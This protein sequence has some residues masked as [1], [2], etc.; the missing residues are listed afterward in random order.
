MK[1]CESCVHKYLS[2]MSDTC[3]KCGIAMLNYEEAKPK[4][5]TNADR[6]RAMSDQELAEF[7]ANV[8]EC[9]FCT[10]KS[11]WCTESEAAC[12]RNWLDWLRQ[13]A[14]E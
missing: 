5:Q 14:K 7:M 11:E 6:I 8:A 13:E 1:D 4:P 2:P 9:Q 3:R 10:V 12:K